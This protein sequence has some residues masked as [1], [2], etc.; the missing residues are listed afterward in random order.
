MP[1]RGPTIPVLTV[2]PKEA[3]W[4]SI[5]AATRSVSIDASHPGFYG[6]P[7]CTYERIRAVAP[8]FYWREQRMW[9]FMNAADVAAILK[10]RRFGRELLPLPGH[11]AEP[12][13]QPH[14]HLQAFHTFNQ[15]SMLEREP[16]AH[17]RLRN[18]VNRAFVTRNIER[19]RPRI[20]ELASSL[21]EAV[22]PR[23]EAELLSAFATPI[24]VTVIAELLGVPAQMAPQLLEWS[25]RMVAIYELGKTRR[26]EDAAE[27]ATREFT[28][29]IKGFVAE[30]RRS[31]ADDL[32]TH[33]IAAEA[34]G[35]TLTEDELA[36][37]CILLLNA[38]HEATVHAIGNS[39][40]TLL[41]Q[42]TDLS[43]AFATDVSTEAAVEE[44]L[45][46]DPPLHLFRRFVQEDLAIAGVRLS[47]GDEVA[48][49]YGAANRD[50][51][52]Y[53]NPD[54]FNPSRPSAGGAAAHAS[55]GG[56]IHFCLGAPLA[57]LE[58]QVAL[59]ILFKHLPGIQ[60]KGR[61]RYR[62]A[63]HFHGLESL[64]VTWP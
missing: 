43:A 62:D 25:H 49:L 15:T 4:L 53:A 31:P 6:D 20:A 30:R 39:V 2:S 51:G 5:D 63:Y 26:T 35:D 10:D 23:H 42:R 11:P 59:P 41:E 45:R 40:K 52:R 18:L 16:P 48:L 34:S 36:G 1:L 47:R 7:Y 55:F 22:K 57:R 58:L 27:A 38:G 54:V 19:L 8:A 64:H 12:A 3:P 44:C 28:A 21:V 33:L 46:F 17:T 13:R 60:L 9:C 14:G 56:G 61:P 37:T 29:F 32:I 50:P 24:P